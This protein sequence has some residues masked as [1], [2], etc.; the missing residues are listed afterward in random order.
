MFA[1]YIGHTYLDK[2]FAEPNTAQKTSPKCMQWWLLT[3]S[4][5]CPIKGRQCQQRQRLA[6]TGWWRVCLSSIFSASHSHLRLG[7]NV[8]TTLEGTENALLFYTAFFFVCVFC[9]PF[10]VSSVVLCSFIWLVSR[11]VKPLQSGDEN[12][13][14]Q[15]QSVN[16]TQCG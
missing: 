15:T 1:L 2:A 13:E 5:H 3:V 12:W 14:K 8:L 4:N 9:F 16:Q 11:D 7:Q 6:E 10:K